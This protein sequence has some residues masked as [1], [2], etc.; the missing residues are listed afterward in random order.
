MDL[1]EEFYKGMEEIS[2][3]WKF[4]TYSIKT[5]YYSPAPMNEIV[6]AG[7]LSRNT[8]NLLIGQYGTG[9]STL[10]EMMHFTFFNDEF[11]NP[12]RIRLFE[13]LTPFDVLFNINIGK[14]VK[15]GVEDI[16]PRRFVTSHFKFINELGRGNTEVYN[17]LLSL[18]AEGYVEYRYKIFKTPDYTCYADMNPKD[19]GSREIPSA[20]WDR[21]NMTIEVPSMGTDD[22]FE[23]MT[24]KYVKTMKRRLTELLEPV[25][26]SKEMLKIW[27]EVDQIK[28]S[29]G[30]I[31]L[32]SL[33]YSAF[34]CPK[35]ERTIID[36]RFTLPCDR[37][38]YKGELCSYISELWGTRW[39]ESTI[40]TAK[41]LAW[42]RDLPIVEIKLILEV[43]PY[44]L[45]HRLI[46]KREY[47]TNY[48]NRFEFITSKVYETIYL[49]R[50]LWKEAI[51]A[52]LKKDKE[53]LTKLAKTDNAIKVFMKK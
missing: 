7:L 29:P 5:R 38:E 12:G 10:I 24:I 51:N 36:H 9:K 50:N 45:A 18:F 47:Y 21:I 46:L 19:V 26:T 31:L 20:F 40:I 15:E 22:I 53:T 44:T 25:M 39:I 33:I 16:T 4:P 30:S 34:K 35:Y 17:A 1:K 8:L 6:F 23:L 32:L 37:C 11:S 52:Y 43:L 13:R 28:V 3:Y 14:L 48:I 2:R 49:K 27:D 41:A 42:I